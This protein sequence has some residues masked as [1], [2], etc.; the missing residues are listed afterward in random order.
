LGVAPFGVICF[1]IISIGISN[2]HHK[3]GAFGRAG[4]VYSY[5]ISQTSASFSDDLLHADA[6]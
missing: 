4:T 1:V 3:K 2:S 5:R 6:L